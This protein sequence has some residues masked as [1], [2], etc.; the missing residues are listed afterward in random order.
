[1]IEMYAFKRPEY[2][3]G[4]I[5]TREIL[6]TMRDMEFDLPYVHYMDCS[7]GVIVPCAIEVTNHSLIIGKG[8]I[9]RGDKLYRM[10]EPAEIEYQP[11]EEWRV[12][13]IQFL[14]QSESKDF[15]LF[16]TKIFLS[17]ETKI[18][19]NELEIC[20]FKLKAGSILRQN[21]LDFHDLNTEFDTLSIIHV[22]FASVPAPTVSPYITRYFARE[23]YPLTIGMPF[24]N[25]FTCACLRDSQPI[26]MDLLVPYI[27][28]RLE[29]T[30]VYYT[31]AEI[32]THL[33]TILADIRRGI[34]VDGYNRKRKSTKIFVD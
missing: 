26:S 31:N 18:E 28:A 5:L 29:L 13:K 12:L 4:R 14:P 9:K 24:D 17:E 22:P 20:R 25:G 27:N 10:M 11:T 3:R 33:S 32:Y 21:Y 8:L 1:M 6:E 2:I 30:K 15:S 34:S 16:E 19:E 23:A 7:D